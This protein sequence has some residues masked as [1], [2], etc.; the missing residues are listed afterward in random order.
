MVH[1]AVGCGEGVSVTSLCCKGV[2]INIGKEQPQRLF[3][4]RY[5]KG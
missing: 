2:E 3:Q 4:P 5:L 1:R